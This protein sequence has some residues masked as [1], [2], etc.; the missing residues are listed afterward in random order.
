MMMDTPG[1]PNGTL[2][3]RLKNS[4]L[5]EVEDKQYM[6]E[7]RKYWPGKTNPLI[8]VAFHNL[9]GKQCVRLV[10]TDNKLFIPVFNKGYKAYSDKNLYDLL[11]P[12]L[13]RP[14]T[15]VRRVNGLYFWNEE[16]VYPE[17]I[18][19]DGD[20][21]AKPSRTNNGVGI[22]KVSSFEEAD[23]L[24]DEDYMIQEIIPQHPEMAK[25]HPMSVNT[26]R[27]ATLRFLGRIHFLLAF[28]RFGN[29]LVNDNFGTG[30]VVCGVRDG[31]LLENG[32]VS[33]E[34]KI[35]IS[36]VHPATG[37]HF[38]GVVPYFSDAVD[39]CIE[40]HRKDYHHG[41]ISWDIAIGPDG[42]VFI[43]ANYWGATWLYQ[44]A[45]EQ[46]LF[47]DLTDEVVREIRNERAGKK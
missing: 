24:F 16:L 19:L 14:V 46:P 38:G 4:G 45:A 36:K 10:P 17:Q 40:L 25:Y 31:R 34:D 28:A 11:Y 47:G 15:Y 23:K 39:L 30:G 3:R 35:L 32:I 42:P 1:I 44:L 5:L 20:F 8:H 9:T 13:R 21:I 29:G 43:E 27:I 7:V 22:N 41:Y 18:K 37:V 26:L 2:Q 6:R 12:T 33:D